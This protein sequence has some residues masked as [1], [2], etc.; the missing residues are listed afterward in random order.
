MPIFFAVRMT[1][2][3]ISPRL[4]TRIFLIIERPRNDSSL[5]RTRESR[6]RSGCWIPACAG[7]TGGGSQRNI[8]VFAPGIFE[9]LVL[10]DREA[11]AY[12][13]SGGVRSYD[14]V[15]EAAMAGDEG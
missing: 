12:P 7:M 14:I 4:A 3:A 11:L 5:P 1:R 8:S 9:L 10:Q 13:P 15:D 2:Q 6:G